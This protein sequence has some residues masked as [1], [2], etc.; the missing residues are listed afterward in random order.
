MM[1]AAYVERF[2]AAE[3][4]R[5]GELPIPSAGPT[6]VL[7]AVQLVAANPVDALVRSGAYPTKV[8]FPFVVGR[9]LVGTV[10]ASGAGAPFQ[11]GE[12][13]WANSLGHDG[14]QGSFAG[15]AVVPAERCY[16]LPEGVD[17]AVAVAAAHP[18]ATAYLG[19]FC[20]GGLRAG[21]CVYV[22]G[23]AGNVGSAAIAMARRAGARV[24]ASAKPADHERCLAL[25]ASEVL[26]YRDPA[27]GEKLL[28]LAPGGLDI[29]WDSSGHN[30][31]GLAAEVLA[32]RGR[33]LI[34][35]AVEERILTPLRRLYTRD[36]SQHGFVISRASSSQLAGAAR[37]VNDMLEAG[38]LAPQIAQ[39]LPLSVTAEVH[40]RL[41]SGRVSGRILLRP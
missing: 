40:A 23:G 35:A 16:R 18:A 14:R 37:L 15:Y 4:I 20:H 29:F 24:L 8:T 38:E 19:W 1:P 30:E 32:P 17:P 34:T 28:D 13:V 12:S 10:A 22:G 21:Q 6:D 26:D 9:D 31:L 11:P 3:E 27:L 5:V 39:V 36:V 7:V 41:E 33:V 2:G 25:G